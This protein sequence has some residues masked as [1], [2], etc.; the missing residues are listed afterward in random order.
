MSCHP[1]MAIKSFSV[2]PSVT[3]KRVCD[4]L[5][6]RSASLAAAVVSD[7]GGF[8]GRTRPMFSRSSSVMRSRTAS[9]AVADV[10]IQRTDDCAVAVASANGWTPIRISSDRH[11]RPLR[12][13]T[14]ALP[15]QHFVG[16]INDPDVDLDILRVSPAPQQCGIAHDLETHAAALPWPRGG[17]ALDQQRRPVAWPRRLHRIVEPRRQA[18]AHGRTSPNRRVRCAPRVAACRSR[19]PVR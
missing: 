7:S 6:L 14:P 13:Q 1:F 17:K 9:G 15:R 11:S 8:S 2:A 18:P 5:A 4:G 19:D 3:R 10:A 16:L 12:R